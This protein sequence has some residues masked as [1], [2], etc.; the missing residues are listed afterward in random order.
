MD[1]T[2][3][4]DVQKKAEDDQINLTIEDKQEA[5]DALVKKDKIPM[6]IPD[7][8][9]EECLKYLAN[10]HNVMDQSRPIIR[11]GDLRYKQFISKLYYRQDGMAN[12]NLAIEFAT[13][14]NKMADELSQKPL[15][16]MLP[17][18]EDDVPKVTVL[19]PVWDYVWNEADTDQELFELFL[20]KNI[21]GTGFW[22]EGLERE[23]CTRYEPVRIG[24]DGE[25]GKKPITETKSWLGGRSLDIRDVWIDPVYTIEQAEDC[26]YRQRDVSFDEV[27]QLINDPNYD[28]DAILSFLQTREGHADVTNSNTNTWYAFLTETESYSYNNE[29]FALMHYFNKRL[30]LYIVT[31][32]DFKF[33][34]RSGANP[35]PHGEL[36]ISV[37]QD[38]KNYRSIYG[39]GECELLESTK[40]ERNM[41]RNQF[42]D[43][44]RF[45]NTQNMMVGSDVTFEDQEMVGGNAR[46]WNFQGDI[47]QVQYMQAPKQ[48]GGLTEAE[49]V[50][51]NDAT[52]L[53]GIDNNSLIGDP[54]NTA[55][56]ARL[57]EQQKLKR[58]FM[59][60]RLADFFYTRM[61]RQRLANI[62]FF[63]PYT[64]G[65]KIIGPKGNKYRTITLPDV[66]AKPNMTVSDKG[67]VE[68]QGVTMEA[69]MGGYEF[70]EC[71][72]QSLK[73]NVD[74]LVTTPSTTP[75]L[76]D[77]N[78]AEL[79][80][81][82]NMV[83][84]LAGSPAA[85]LPKVA[86][87]LKKFDPAQM[88]D[89]AVEAL[90]YDPDT[91]FGGGAEQV[92]NEQQKMMQDMMSQ[93]PTPPNLVPQ[94]DKNALQVPGQA[95]TPPQ[96][97][98]QGE[99]P[100]MP[101]QGGVPT[102]T[103]PV[104]AGLMPAGR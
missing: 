27:Q 87:F 50:L 1:K 67:E 41:I 2:L 82:Q 79:K 54:S 95:P 20:C 16:T 61:G 19:K 39:R 14:E 60:L 75:I 74:I 40:Y 38:H 77:L 55:F 26:F 15:V 86:E 90:G 83:I 104:S 9:Q 93:L 5:I 53:T 4:K 66:K 36:P 96:I 6:Y 28:K 25:I 72:P 49:D 22:L 81:I 102:Q 100:M 85:Q 63:L 99:A 73:S 84:E 56:E 32:E 29:K 42:L 12:V 64:T 45:S 37:L 21:F 62:Q 76:R 17:Q 65:K 47:R 18:G 98:G 68:Q 52:W 71:T 34:F 35:Y 43:S 3:Y 97:A 30:G 10:R 23:T 94:P 59:S 78:R 89:D 88:Y 103:Q 44:V 80:E 24:T 69:D 11:D 57:Q 33:I 7:E 91:Y 48:D 13:I 101:Q 58:I 46:V 70:F 92:Q 31:D 8:E 51:K